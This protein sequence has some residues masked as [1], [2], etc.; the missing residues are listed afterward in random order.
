MGELIH[1]YLKEMNDLKAFGYTHR[2]ALERLAREQ[3]GAIA[4]TALTA[5]DVIEHCRRRRMIV[6]AATVQ[7]DVTYLR[8][9][10]KIAK[11]MWKVDVTTKPL[12]DALP[13]LQKWNLIGKSRPRTQ[14]P[15]EEQLVQ[16][17]EYFRKQ[18]QHWRTRIPMD[19][20]TEFQVASS[21]RI[22]ETCRIRW[23]DLDH[24][25]HCVLV[26]DMKD[27]KKKEGNHRKVFLPPRAW[28]II[29]AQPRIDGEPRIFPYN[30]KSASGRYTLAKKAL[31]IKNLRLHDNRRECAT[32]LIEQEGYSIPEAMLV[33]GHVSAATLTRVY[34]ALKPESLIRGPL[35]KRRAAND[36][37]FSQAA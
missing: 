8:G 5:Q 34:M 26:R 1:R 21:R 31:G 9:P 13:M 25:N 37:Q 12:D 4:A 18:N 32:R 14:R 36:E 33:T 27:P 3:I 17:T 7:Q 19:V 28:A 24:E 2:Y 35:A 11:M 20:V 10:F 15:T 16:L 6:C 29:M 30:P 22:S 23:D